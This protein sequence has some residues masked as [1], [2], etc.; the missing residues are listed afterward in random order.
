[1]ASASSGLQIHPRSE[2][3]CE[4]ETSPEAPRGRKSKRG[5]QTMSKA[6]KSSQE[7]REITFEE[8]YERL[9]AIAARIDE[10]EVPVSELCELFAEGK[11]LERAL[12]SY[13]E[14]Q[15]GRL[16]E[17]ERGEGVA[18]FQVVSASSPGTERSANSEPP[19]DEG[20]LPIDESDLPF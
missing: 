1:M 12:S 15:Q 18:S 20:R 19:E 14:S 13:L 10:E 9:K 5:A 6:T 11:G 8:G 3:T 16:E 2:A 7:P 4:D 17:I